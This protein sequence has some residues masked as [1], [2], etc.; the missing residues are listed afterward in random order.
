MIGKQCECLYVLLEWL[1]LACKVFIVFGEH[2]SRESI[3][4]LLSKTRNLSG[5]HIMEDMAFIE[6]SD[7]G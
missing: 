4:E 2:D 7:I 1:S 6:D 3:N 5:L